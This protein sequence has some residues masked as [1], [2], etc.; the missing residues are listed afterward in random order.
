MA[1]KT[2][3]GDSSGGDAG[4]SGE[5]G[6]SPR[7]AIGAGEIHVG[8]TNFGIESFEE[9][10]QRHGGHHPDHVAGTGTK[11]PLEDHERAIGHAIH[12]TKHH[13][14]AQA[15]PHH[16]PHHPEGYMFGHQHA[17]HPEHRHETESHKERLAGH[18]AKA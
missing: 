11:E 12:H 3:H 4:Y 15:A 5:K 2:S 6:M 10:A 9:G 8:G 1:R 18:R 16:G 13:H 17:Q 14:P 7:K